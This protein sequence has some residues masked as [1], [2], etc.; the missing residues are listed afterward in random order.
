[1]ARDIVSISSKET[2]NKTSI[3]NKN[4]DGDYVSGPE[5]LG[6]VQRRSWNMFFSSKKQ[7]SKQEW[8]LNSWSHWSN[9]SNN[10]VRNSNQT[11]K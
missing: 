9:S 4:V 8:Y 10:L 5:S 2:S 7:W 3:L 11:R 6:D 1:M